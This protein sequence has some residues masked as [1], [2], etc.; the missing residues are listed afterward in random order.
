V[1]VVQTV[2]WRYALVVNRN[3]RLRR[4]ACRQATRLPYNGCY[5]PAIIGDWQLH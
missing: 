1:V 4:A 3:E 2:T 5:I